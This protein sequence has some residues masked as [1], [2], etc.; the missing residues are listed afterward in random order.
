MMSSVLAGA[1]RGV[2]WLLAIAGLLAVTLAG[3]IAVPVSRPKALASISD[4]V[5]SADRDNVPPLQYFQAR[6]GSSLAYRRYVPTAPSANRAAILVHGSS[7]SS[8]AMHALAKALAAR[9][10]E[11]VAPDIR[12]HGASGTRGD[13]GYLG[14]LDDDLVELVGHLRNQGL[15]APLTL[16]GH[17]SGAGFA[18]RVAGSVNQ[19]LFARTVLLSPYLGIK[20]PSTRE[21]AGGW[22][23][24][25]VPRIIALSVLQSFG[26]TCCGHL[27][28]VAFAT[29]PNSARILTSEYSFRL[30]QNFG[31][32]RDYRLDLAPANGPISVIAGRDDELMFADKYREALQT[33]PT[34]DVRVLDN[35]NHMDI[36]STAR[37]I[38]VVADDLATR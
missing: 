25:S 34:I 28:V 17:S 29:P 8:M 20:A 7:G 22:A 30:L 3:M 24:P 36:V 10:V 16:A 13:I 12:G 2:V 5:R 18:L 37:F 14:Q 33:K 9:G 35:A 26:V 21:N 11:S 19:A 15:A 4:T 27:P 32:H 31:T 23:S 1:F 6:D 38:A